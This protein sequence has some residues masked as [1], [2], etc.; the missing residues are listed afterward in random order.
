[1]K[2]NVGK[3]VIVTKRILDLEKIKNAKE[4]TPDE[5]RNAAFLG[6][7]LLQAPTQDQTTEFDEWE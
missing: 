7:R 3:T 2:I 6:E 4:F 1:M 5:W